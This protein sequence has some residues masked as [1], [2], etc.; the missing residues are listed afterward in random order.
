MTFAVN[1][2]PITDA[3]RRSLGYYIQSDGHE[4][5][6]RLVLRFYYSGLIHC[7]KIFTVLAVGLALF[8]PSDTTISLRSAMLAIVA[9]LFIGLVVLAIRTSYASVEHWRL[10]QRVLDWDSVRKLHDSGNPKSQDRG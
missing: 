3:Q 8:T 6:P 5:T 2:D 1:D 10:L 9:C 4:I 7:A